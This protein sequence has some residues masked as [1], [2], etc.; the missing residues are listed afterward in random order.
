[1]IYLLQITIYW[2]PEKWW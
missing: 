1:V 2:R